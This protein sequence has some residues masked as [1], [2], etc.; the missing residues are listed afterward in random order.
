M[1]AS[2]INTSQPVLLAAI[3]GHAR[4]LSPPCFTT[5]FSRQNRLYQI[6]FRKSNL[7]ILS[8][9]NGLHHVGNS[10]KMS[11][12]CRLDNDRPTSLR[13]LLTWWF[14]HL[15]RRDIGY[16]GHRMLKMKLPGRRI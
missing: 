14:G 2:L 11:L 12:D 7:T 1:V 9:T 3:H 13:V 5:V 15:K 10:L 16:T 4:V 8:V 6:F